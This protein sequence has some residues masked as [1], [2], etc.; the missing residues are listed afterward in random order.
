MPAPNAPLGIEEYVPPSSGAKVLVLGCIDPRFSALLSEFLVEYKEVQFI[1]DL[2]ILA[3]S[4]LGAN[5]SYLTYPTVLRTAGV[6][7]AQYPL[8]LIPQWG[9]NWGPT[10]FD[11]IGIAILLHNITE[12]WVFD[13]LDCGAYKRIKFGNAAATDN[14]IAQHTPELIKLQGYIKQTS[15]ALAYKGF[16]MDMTG[17]ITKVVDDGLGIQFPN[18]KNFGSS[19]IRNPA[20]DYTNTVLWRTSDYST[21][22]IVSNTHRITI[23]R[24]C[25]CSSSTLNTKS[26]NCVKCAKNGK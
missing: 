3:G 7:G 24:I 1:Y 21:E 9:V 6:A 20:S 12:V 10:F 13:H 15:P 16:V 4:S 11:H 18:N 26:G 2:F 23:T 14:D 22:R 5:Q 17:N 19:N 25:D 8:N